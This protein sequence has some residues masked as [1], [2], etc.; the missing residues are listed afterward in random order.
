MITLI[1]VTAKH[2]KALFRWRNDPT[3]YRH[4]L[5]QHPVNLREH[6]MWF[7]KVLGDPDC[8]LLI[9]LNEEKKPIGQVRFD[10]DENEA[11]INITIAKEF[12]GLGYGTKAI[13][14]S[15]DLFLENQPGIK[16]IIAKVKTENIYSIRS[17]I[18]AGYLKYKSKSDMVYLEFKN[19][20]YNK[21]L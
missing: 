5:N 12:R 13:K 19:E 1:L 2:E 4:F 3:A 10:I 18:G 11:E 14:K 9:A 17:F 20:H 8:R 16:K 15:S 21:D 7:K 6:K